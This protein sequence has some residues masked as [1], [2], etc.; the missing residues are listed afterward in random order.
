[1]WF[2]LLIPV[3]A[4]LYRR[5][6]KWYREPYLMYALSHMSRATALPAAREMLEGMAA[7]ESAAFGMM[8][9]WAVAFTDWPPQELQKMF[10][11]VY[12]GRDTAK[13]IIRMQ[14]LAP[15]LERMAKFNERPVLLYPFGVADVHSMWL[16]QDW[17]ASLDFWV[18][19]HG[20]KALSHDLARFPIFYGGKMLAVGREVQLG[21]DRFGRPVYVDLDALPTVHGV[22]LGASGMGKSWTVGSWLNILSKVGVR[23]IITDPHGDYVKWALLNGAQ[24][25]EVPAVLPEDMPGVWPEAPGSKGCCKSTAMSR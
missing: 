25:L 20:V 13:R 22:I 23:I 1:M 21:F 24:V 16:V 17:A 2:L 8:Q 14:E 6:R 12:E 7:A 5:V 15:L 10:S 3:W 19:K 9:K 4:L 18:L 11:R